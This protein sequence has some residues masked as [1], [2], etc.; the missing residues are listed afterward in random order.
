VRTGAVGRLG[1]DP[2]WPGAC[3]ERPG[4]WAISEIRQGLAGLR[5]L[6]SAMGRSSFLSLLAEA[7]AR[8]GRLE[9]SLKALDEALEFTDATGE[10]FWEAELHRLKAELLLRRDP[11]AVQSAEVCYHKAL[12]IA[13][14]Q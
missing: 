6:G 10:H 14:R 9:E 8:S 5:T 1:Q 2:V 3:R 7:C 11:T 13:R 12:K 4:E